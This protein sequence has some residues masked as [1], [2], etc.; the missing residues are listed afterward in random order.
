MH[1]TVQRTMVDFYSIWLDL[2]IRLTHQAIATVTIRASPSLLCTWVEL[3]GLERYPF[4]TPTDKIVLTAQRLIETPA[5][6]VQVVCLG[7][8]DASNAFMSSVCSAAKTGYI[9]TLASL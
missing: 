3:K 2:P 8:S 9:C 7:C 4:N 6:C 5:G 1:V